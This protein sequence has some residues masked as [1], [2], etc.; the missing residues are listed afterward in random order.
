MI[1]SSNGQT[2][3][4]FKVTAHLIKQGNDRIAHFSG[5]GNLNIYKDRFNGYKKAL[6]D[7]GKVFDPALVFESRLLIE[8]GIEGIKHLLSLPNR[9]DALFSSNDLAAIAAMKYIS[10]HTEFSVPED[11]AV[12]GF[13]NSPSASIIEPGLTTVDQ[14]GEEMGKIAAKRLI[15]EIK[16]EIDKCT[17]EIITVNSKIIVRESSV[18]RVAKLVKEVKS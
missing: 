14:S 16:G 11:I 1:I 13:S 12:A 3:P 8:D 5:P 4:S 10:Q 17:N 6:E 18:K 7:Y 15:D 2:L 9:P